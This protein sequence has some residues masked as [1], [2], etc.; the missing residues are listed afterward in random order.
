MTQEWQSAPPYTW[1]VIHQETSAHL[2]STSQAGSSA[3]AEAPAR[4]S[5]HSAGSSCS[6]RLRQTR[7]FT[8]NGFLVVT[9]RVS[10]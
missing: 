9:W 10:G 6:A 3:A 7:L 1:A 4:P 8:L 5:V 2:N